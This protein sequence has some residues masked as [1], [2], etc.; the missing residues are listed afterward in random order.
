VAAAAVFAL[1][2]VVGCSNTPTAPSTTPTT[3]TTPTSP[4]TFSSIVTK[5][6]FTSH[7]FISSKTG[8]YSVTL[9]GFSAPVPIGLGIGI[10]NASGAGCNLN[11]TASA[12]PSSTAQLA[13]NID[14]G[15]YCVAVFDTGSLPGDASFAVVIVFP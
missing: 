12:R 8:A 4:Q 2:S 1:T 3:P 14:A 13:G 11:T 9:T 5:G 7:A 6:G 15:T 10:P